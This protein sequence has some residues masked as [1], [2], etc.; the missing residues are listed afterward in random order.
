MFALRYDIYVLVW[1]VEHCRTNRDFLE[2][3][4]VNFALYHKK[5]NFW[6]SSYTFLTTDFFRHLNPAIS[7]FATLSLPKRLSRLQVKDFLWKREGHAERAWRRLTPV[8]DRA[9][10]A[11]RCSA[12]QVIISSSRGTRGIADYYKPYAAILR[13]RHFVP[14]Q[15][16]FIN[17]RH[18]ESNALESPKK[19]ADYF[20]CWRRRIILIIR[21]N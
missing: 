12:R 20:W 21:S 1:G 3:M 4:I 10:A 14:A 15:N 17:I 11:L 6:E 5:N 19:R 9:H 18:S 2:K 8:K 7:H 16:D 13:R